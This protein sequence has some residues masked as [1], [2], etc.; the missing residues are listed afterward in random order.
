M[1]EA[2]DTALVRTVVSICQ[3]V[4][5]FG[6]PAQPHLPAQ[7]EMHG[8]PSGVQI[9]EALSLR[10]L[11]V[12]AMDLCPMGIFSLLAVRQRPIKSRQ[13]SLKPIASCKNLNEIASSRI[14]G[15]RATVPKGRSLQC[16]QQSSFNPIF[17]IEYY[18]EVGDGR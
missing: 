7:I 15:L 1:Y 18:I 5:I 6:S 12:A 11:P 2:F 16:V 14:G 10:S 13:D 4:S 9:L 17:A 8:A 3:P